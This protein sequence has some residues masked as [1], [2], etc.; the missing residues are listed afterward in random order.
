MKKSQAT[1][2]YIFLI[3]LVASAI[4]AM[5]FYISRGLQGNIRN[6]TDQLGAGQ[7]E[8][9]KTKV[10]NQ[11]VKHLQAKVSSNTI[12]TTVYGNESGIIKIQDDMDKNSK[13]M[14]KLFGDLSLFNYKWEKALEYEAQLRL[15]KDANGFAILWNSIKSGFGIQDN[16]GSDEDKSPQY[17]L[18]QIKESMEANAKRT[19]ELQ[20]QLAKIP[21]G[22]E[23]DE[24]RKMLE[25]QVIP[26]NI[27]MGETLEDQY[28][29]LIFD[30]KYKSALTGADWQKRNAL[31]P[32]GAE[33]STDT[34][35]DEYGCSESVLDTTIKN[36][37]YD[38]VAQAKY[39]IAARQAKRA[40][41]AK[42]SLAAID[43]GNKN[44]VTEAELQKQTDDIYTAIKENTPPPQYAVAMPTECS[45]FPTDPPNNQCSK[46]FEDQIKA[47]NAKLDENT[48]A[49]KKLKVDL[50]SA[51]EKLVNTKKSTS[52]NTETGSITIKKITN[53]TLGDL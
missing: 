44:P 53:E 27:A 52:S 4:I 36:P 7:F 16:T 8:H 10:N 18:N 35:C 15:T 1:I 32:S 38:S 46:F 25:E 45:G 13:E 31:V 42:A 40:E 29:N 28:E 24:R 26:G 5:L 37:P 33:V 51:E 12:T 22:P 30:D 2:E 3:A 20:D 11:E 50:E 14:N 21:P 48:A 43:N 34:Y 6:K 17:Q 47:I 39:N 41:E 9:G 49:Y 19:K 23:Y